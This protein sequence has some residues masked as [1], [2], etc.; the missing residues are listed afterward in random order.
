VIHLAKPDTPGF[1][2]SIFDEIPKSEVIQLLLVKLCYS[3]HDNVQHAAMVPQGCICSQNK[4]S[5]YKPPLNRDAPRGESLYGTTHL[6]SH[7]ICNGYWYLTY[8]QPSATMLAV[9]L[10][11]HHLPTLYIYTG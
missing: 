8:M 11:V 1:E 2:V 6:T 4:P 10:H 9:C 5:H 7:I 3:C